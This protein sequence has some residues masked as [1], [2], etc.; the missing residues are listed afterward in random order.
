[1]AVSALECGCDSVFVGPKGWSRRPASDELEDAEIRELIQW[2]AP[3]EKDIRIAINVMP[4]PEE[5]S[6]F[7]AKVERYAAWGANGVMICDP[8]CIKLGAR[9]LSLARHSRQRHGRVL[10]CARH[11]VLPGSRREHCGHSLS[12]GFVRA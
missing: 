1:M 7:L 10:Q 12:L 5:M 6:A 3:R 4:A 11:P 8:G 9:A 2:A